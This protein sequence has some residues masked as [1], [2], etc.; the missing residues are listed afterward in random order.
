[1]ERADALKLVAGH[2]IAGDCHAGPIG[3]RQVLVVAQATFHRAAR[4]R[5]TVP[6]AGTGSF[7]YAA[8]LR[9]RRL[10]RGRYRLVAG[11]AAN[12]RGTDGTT[13]KNNSRAPSGTSGD[14]RTSSRSRPPAAPSRR[15]ER[16]CCSQRGFSAARRSA[17]LPEAR[18]V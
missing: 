8:R 9:G 15:S 16:L 1:M 14:S 11:P 13:V 18:A 12:G 17:D 3:P 6:G 7:R 10:P 4:V 2:G 5:L